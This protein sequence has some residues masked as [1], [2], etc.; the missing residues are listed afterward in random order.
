[1]STHKSFLPYVIPPVAFDLFGSIFGH[2]SKW[3]GTYL[4]WADAA[5][6]SAGYDA[7]VIFER[8]QWAARQVR[9]G[10]ALWERDATCFFQEDYNWQLLACLMTVAARSGGKLHV[11]DFGGALGST[12]AQHRKLLSPLPEH[13]WS[14]V[15]QAHVARSGEMEFKFG[16]LDFWLMRPSV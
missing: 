10:K 16:A 3:T 14:V 12:Y 5:A 7:A 15:E 11:M 6:A 2:R 13:S 8:T 1:M 9:D 4:T